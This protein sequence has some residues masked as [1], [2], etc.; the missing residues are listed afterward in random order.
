MTEQDK[1]EQVVTALRSAQAAA[2]DAALQMLNGL[3]GLVRSPSDAQPLETEE[4]RS[5]A[6][7]SICE[8][9]KALHR[10]QPTE[11]LWPAA[12]SASERWLR[13]AR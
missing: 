13:L 4:A 8:V 10:G 11:A 1:A 7:M 2:P 12:V 9:G 6:F 3:M 5:S